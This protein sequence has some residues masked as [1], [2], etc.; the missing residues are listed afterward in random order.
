MPG[1]ESTRGHHDG[2][3]DVQVEAA[4]WR[5]RLHVGA[6][7]GILVA[8]AAVLAVLALASNARPISIDRDA[9][10]PK[11]DDHSPTAA[12]VVPERPATDPPR[13]APAATPTT[14]PTPAPATTTTPTPVPGEPAPPPSSATRL[15]HSM[16]GSTAPASRPLASEAAAAPGRVAPSVENSSTT[17]P[18]DRGRELFARRWRPNDPRSRGGDG[19]GPVYNAD[20]CLACHFQGGPGGSGP[21]ES[22]VTI[23][24]RP[25]K[26]A[27]ACPPTFARATAEFVGRTIHR[28]I[29]GAGEWASV[30]PALAKAPGV[31]VHR[32]GVDPAYASLRAAVLELAYDPTWKDVGKFVLAE[33]MRQPPANCEYVDTTR[34]LDRFLGLP[35]ARLAQRSTPPLFG[36][37]LIDAIPDRV[38]LEEEARQRSHP[39][40]A[41]RA[42]RLKNGRIGRFG[43]KAETASLEEFVRLAS[44]NEL[45]LEV[46]GQHQAAPA[47]GPDSSAPPG[48]DLDRSDCD[49]LTAYV[50]QLPAPSLRSSTGSPDRDDIEAGRRAF[51]AIGCADCHTPSLG[52]I[53][54]LYS[55]LLL[56][57]LG[58]PLASLAGEYSGSAPSEAEGSSDP[59]A[60]GDGV[61]RTAP[62]WGLAASAPYLHDGR[63]QTLIEA[64]AAHR[65]QGERAS[66]NYFL[67]PEV[68]RNQI[69]AFLKALAPPPP[70]PAPAAPKADGPS[71][72]ADPSLGRWRSDLQTASLRTLKNSVDFLHLGVSSKLKVAKNLEKTGK[73]EA[74]LQTYRKLIEDHPGSDEAR[75]ARA[76]I[77]ELER[78]SGPR[79]SVASHR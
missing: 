59:S 58:Q 49:A 55:D 37:G 42:H 68:R 32:H 78:K 56:H 77:A 50:R 38:L 9:S 17:N 75:S 31:V 72:A 29:S 15:R 3:Q 39:K 33:R 6:L 19:L 65:A 66:K 67:Q 71:L 21:V 52:G 34:G 46:P 41:G 5:T 62:L 23:V 8:S 13:S 43:W 35:A 40:T 64:I 25:S 48:L 27:A 10:V 28:P 16:L 14:T 57:D 51:E 24:T 73:T 63:A 30:L 45:G 53:D 76:R 44:A 2:L 1:P 36:T 4:R 69:L 7:A 20:S 47:F 11:P 79:R 12:V 60:P 54:G 18:V 61:W 22:N 74:A 26:S 70:P